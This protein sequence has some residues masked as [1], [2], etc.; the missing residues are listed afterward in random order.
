MSSNARAAKRSRRSTAGAGE[1]CWMLAKTAHIIQK[2][3]KRR[4]TTSVI[5][6]LDQLV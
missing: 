6:R 5:E 3:G 4:E 2:H 1:G